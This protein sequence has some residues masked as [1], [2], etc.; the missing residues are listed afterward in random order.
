MLLLPLL[1]AVR[2]KKPLLLLLPLL[3]KH[4]LLL[5][6]HL[7]LKHLLLPLPHQQNHNFLWNEK[8]TLRGG[9]FSSVFFGSAERNQKTLLDVFSQYFDDSLRGCR[10]LGLAIRIQNRH[11]GQFTLAYNRNLVFDCFSSF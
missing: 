6:L 4:L 3:L 2:K 9:F 8:T 11:R 7:L 5:P 1:L 10:G